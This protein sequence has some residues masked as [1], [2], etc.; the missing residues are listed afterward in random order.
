MSKNDKNLVIAVIITTFIALALYFFLGV[1]A[2]SYARNIAVSNLSEVTKTPFI[3]IDLLKGGVWLLY[4]V[5]I[6]LL[7]SKWWA[8]RVKF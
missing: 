2:Q 5:A 3:I 8:R 6:I 4:A 1:I 7:I